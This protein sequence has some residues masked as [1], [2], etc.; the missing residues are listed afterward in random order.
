MNAPPNLRAVQSAILRFYRSYARDLPWRR[1][2]SPYRI[3]VSEVMLQQTQVDRVIPK[4]RLFLLRFPTLRALARARFAQVLRVWVGLGYNGRAL[5]LWRCARALARD[6]GGKLP[7]GAREL[8]QL[9]GVGA[10]TAAAVSSFAFGA[11]VPVVDTNV[12]RVLSRSLLG[13][14]ATSP[15]RISLLAASALPATPSAEWAQALMDVGALFCKAT[16]RCALCPARNVCA[17]AN[18]GHHERTRAAGVRKHAPFSGSARFYRG[19]VMRALSTAVSLRIWALGRQ[20]KDGFGVSDRPWLREILHGLE[21]DGL[22]KL[23]RAR[24]R[25]RL[26]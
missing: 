2:K 4:Y 8:Q 16:P 23:D 26:P 3:L 24:N 5:R 19:R 21:H 13:S 20:V 12:R 18:N 14:D 10:Y 7:A 6:H 17:Y 25:V 22:I 15:A 9:P 1:T 11:Q